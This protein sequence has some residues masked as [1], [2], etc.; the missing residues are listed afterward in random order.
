MKFSSASLFSLLLATASPAF[1]GS[2]TI[3]SDSFESGNLTLPY[4]GGLNWANTNRTSLVT[5]D[6]VMGDLILYQNNSVVE[7][8]SG[9][10]QQWVARD[11]AVSLRFEY[12]PGVN[13]WSEQRFSLDAALPEVW[14]SYWL[15][16]PTNFRHS[17]NS[18][19]NNKLFALW[20]DGYSSKGDGP[21]V[22]W[23]FWNDGAGGSKLAYHYSPGG[24]VT[25]GGHRQHTQFI[26]YPDDQGRWMKIV[27]HVRAA[28]GDGANDGVIQLYRRW[29]N[30]SSFTLF[31]E[32]TN[33]DIAPPAGGPNGWKAGYLMGWS[34][35]GYSETTEWLLD[36]FKLSASSL[37]ET[38]DGSTSEPTGGTCR[39]PRI[40]DILSAAG[41]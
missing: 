28:S 26:R 37:L 32:D 5:S 27:M 1:S 12:S 10:D 3:L 13:S 6:P 11:G 31:H 16:V 23:E 4:S 7:V 40:P 2:P 41:H 18:P 38:P 29:E 8:Q 17:S 30:E 34:N 21:T 15:R 36:D 14:I 33:A 22:I 19:S 35:P 9:H 24:Y 25:A 20:M 39:E